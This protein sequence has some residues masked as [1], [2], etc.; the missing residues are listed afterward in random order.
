MPRQEVCRGPVRVVQGLT[1]ELLCTVMVEADWDIA[2]LKWEVARAVGIPS[3]EQRLLVNDRV[4]HNA[5]EMSNIFPDLFSEV[6]SAEVTLLRLDPKY[7]Q[8]IRDVERGQVRLSD[9]DEDLRQDRDVVFAAMRHT[10]NSLQMVPDT[11]RN[12][13]DVVRAALQTRPCALEHA[14]PTL[15]ADKQ[16]VMEAVTQN[17][18][19]VQYASSCLLSDIDVAAAAVKQNGY[20]LELL[21]FEIR[22]RRDIV[23][24]ALQQQGEA[25]RFLPDDLRNDRELVLMAVRSNSEALRCIPAE[26]LEDKEVLH[27]ASFG[28]RLRGNFGATAY[29]NR[30]IKQ[31][32]EAGA[33]RPSRNTNLK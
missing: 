26:F 12:D 33:S 17:G 27:A 16:L 30:M 4:A 28:I 14:S 8:T 18:L 24:L 6:G 20:S 19:A 7:A 10:G 29:F 11:L 25:F 32:K 9:I 1:A 15:Q 23:T 5:E 3:Q 21:P 13:R 22:G 2:D 31:A